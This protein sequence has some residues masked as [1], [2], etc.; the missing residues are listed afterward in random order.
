MGMAL[1]GHWYVVLQIIQS[2]YLKNTSHLRKDLIYAER[3][4]LLTHCSSTILGNLLGDNASGD[5]VGDHK[6][7]LIFAIV[8]TFIP[9]II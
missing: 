8:G 3:N 4:R 6:I 2:C 9:I 5:T 7:A 1:I